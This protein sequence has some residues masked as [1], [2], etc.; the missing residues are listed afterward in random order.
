[1]SA[2]DE[3]KE[4]A[5]KIY[6]LAN[7]AK[8]LLLAGNLQDY[9][10]KEAEVIREA[11]ALISDYPD[12][13][14][15]YVV[16]SSSTQILIQSLSDYADEH[17]SEELLRHVFDMTLGVMRLIIPFAI[18]DSDE[19]Y[20]ANLLGGSVMHMYIIMVQ[21]FMKTEA[22]DWV[23]R[24]DAVAA[25]FPLL[26]SATL[27]L[28]RIN[29]SSEMLQPL[30]NVI[31]QVD[32]S[33]LDDDEM[34][35]DEMTGQW[36]AFIKSLAAM[37]LTD[38]S[39]EDH[40]DP[41][42]D[43]NE[44]LQAYND[45]MQ[46]YNDLR[47]KARHVQNDAISRDFEKFNDSSMELFDELME[48]LNENEPSLLEYAVINE[49]F[50]RIIGGFELENAQFGDTDEII[51]LTAYTAYNKMSR[52]L[53]KNISDRNA[54]QLYLKNVVRLMLKADS[55][56]AT[57]PQLD[58]EAMDLFELTIG[59]IFYA[60]ME[61]VVKVAPD[62]PNPEE[63]YPVF[64]RIVKSHDNFRRTDISEL[65]SLTSSLQSIYDI[66]TDQQ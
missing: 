50:D 19:Q 53:I 62:T 7:M 21:Y 29:P 45:V 46:P 32:E 11:E 8:G 66:L 16:V 31:R 20:G 57:K 2:Y 42:A 56:F 34:T 14:A 65:D 47:L 39:K 25:F 48:R 28:R 30:I 64:E 15:A 51:F 60:T 4:R 10:E 63:A 17:P 22:F 26:V 33:V 18:K 6:G 5:P 38:V 27:R 61:H 40:S 12:V 55:F 35:T 41:D 44:I 1:M 9:Y 54:A 13:F 58:A 23:P 59:M 24:Q 52:F 37:G 43:E 3:V 36:T 49:A